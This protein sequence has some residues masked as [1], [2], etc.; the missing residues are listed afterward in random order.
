MM[1]AETSRH[2]LQAHQVHAAAL[3]LARDRG[4][5]WYLGSRGHR[6]RQGF[7]A[8]GVTASVARGQDRLLTVPDV[9]TI[10]SLA[11]R[12]I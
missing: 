7:G 11:K 8:V 10:L 9:A 4:R 6:H 12:T 2:L 1:D 3:R 5:R